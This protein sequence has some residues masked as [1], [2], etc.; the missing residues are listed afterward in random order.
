LVTPLW[1][2]ALIVKSDPSDIPPEGDAMSNANGTTSRKIR[3]FIATIVMV[4]AVLALSACDRDPTPIVDNGPQSPAMSL[5]MRDGLPVQ[6]AQGDA[7]AASAASY[8]NKGP[9]DYKLGAKDRV[10]IIVLGQDKLT[11]EYV[12]DGNGVLAFPLVGQLQANG[13]TPG[14]LEKAIVAKLDPDYIRN[15]SVSVEVLSRR[16]FFIL[17]E[18][19]R[20]GSY[21]HMSEI[22]VLT[23]V[24]TAGGFTYRARESQF[25]IKRLDHDGKMVRVPA[26]GETLVRPGDIVQVKERYF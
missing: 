9:G 4:G 16:P 8:D 3:G 18:V 25:Y 10:R 26:T 1:W 24:A 17:G 21:P 20:P 6:G 11:G 2:H 12:L 5:Q 7:L 22:N 13:M 19:Q 15:P 23:A 14:Q